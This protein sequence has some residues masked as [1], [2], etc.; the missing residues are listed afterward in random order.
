MKIHKYAC[1]HPHAELG[2]DVEVGPFSV[3]D[4]HV[5]IG[6]GTVIKNN[7]TVNGNTIIGKDNVIFPNAVVG[8]EPQDLKYHGE[9]TRLIIGDNNVIRECVTINTGTEFGG[10]ETVIGNGNFL[11][12]CCHV[13]H[14]CIIEDNVL[15]TN[16]TLL[17]G[18]IK[19]E[20]NAKLMGLVGIQPFVTI[21]Q[22]AYVGGLARI[23]QD[24]PPYM[25]VE[26]NPAKVRQ[27]NVIGLE[28]GGFSKERI[29]ALEDAF[30]RIF[31][32][33]IL[34]RSKVLDELEA[35]DDILPEVQYLIT[36]LRNVDK[37]RFGRFRES[38]RRI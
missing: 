3:I 31:R 27:V 20:K 26:G 11:M 4:E 12:A 23:V 29:D 14:D 33:E 5:K 6:D 16:G 8:S 17:G 30:R 15:L 22:Y 34:N 13:A 36:F 21:G 24:V 7:V 9:Q 18:H 2:S 28:R 19:I 37:G 25:I 32:P 1:V 38:L 35:E 10:G